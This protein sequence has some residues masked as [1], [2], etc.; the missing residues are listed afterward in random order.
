MV[1]R[2]HD[3]YWHGQPPTELVPKALFHVQGRIQRGECLRLRSF[4]LAWQSVP[5][6]CGLLP[7]ERVGSQNLRRR[8]GSNNTVRVFLSTRGSRHSSPSH[9]YPRWSILLARFD[10]AP[11]LRGWAAVRKRSLQCGLADR[12]YSIFLRP[13]NGLRESS[14]DH[15]GSWA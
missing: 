7:F 15:L 13:E 12:L 4:A 3:A 1:I 10:T 5:A 11:S 9:A 14:R 6:L 8:P 2:E